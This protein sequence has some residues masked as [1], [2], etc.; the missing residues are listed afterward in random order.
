MRAHLRSPAP[1]LESAT[2]TPPT[3]RPG[4]GAEPESRTR[5]H[6]A[7]GCGDQW[8]RLDDRYGAERRY[9]PP[10]AMART[11]DGPPTGR[12]TVTSA[13]GLPATAATRHAGHL[14]R[15]TSW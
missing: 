4:Y 14:S 12:R 11:P 7:P 2:G 1:A 8:I 13:C 5:R 15:R 9:Q 6:T 10:R 3:T